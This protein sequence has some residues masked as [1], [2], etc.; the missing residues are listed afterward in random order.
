MQQQTRELAAVAAVEAG[1]AANEAKKLAVRAAN[2]AKRLLIE[3][4]FVQKK[5]LKEGDILRAF[6]G[7]K[8]T[9]VKVTKINQRGVKT[10]SSDA[11]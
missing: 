7:R 5:D 1:Y 4:Q 10:Y 6:Y 9:L 3:Q 2:L 8:W 11:S